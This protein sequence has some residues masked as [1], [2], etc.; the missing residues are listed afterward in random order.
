MFNRIRQI[1]LFAA[2][3][4]TMFILM[5]FVSGVVLIFE[6]TFPGKDISV[7]RV[8]TIIPGIGTMKGDTLIASL[9][10]HLNVSGRHQIRKDGD[11]TL[12]NFIHPGM[13]GRIVVANDSDSVAAVIHERNLNA[14]LIQ[15]H[16]L[17]GYH[18]GWR[19]WIW[20]FFYDLSALS[21]IVFAFTGVYL[22]YKTERVKWPGW[23]LLGVTTFFVAFTLY[24][25]QYLN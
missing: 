4:L 14:T 15:F 6:E 21:M 12:V 19:Y 2:L 24:Y 10:D 22:W 17:H 1:H 8:N 11:Q 7:A 13:E 9:E 5:Y 23:L 20:A 3:I 18:G 16:R 25:L